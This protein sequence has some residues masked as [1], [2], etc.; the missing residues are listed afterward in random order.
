MVAVLGE[1]MFSGRQGVSNDFRHW[2]IGSKL[3]VCVC[4]QQKIV[5]LYAMQL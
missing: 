3:D 4:S 2:K 5:L 1:S